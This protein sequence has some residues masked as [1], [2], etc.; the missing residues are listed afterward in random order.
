MDFYRFWA[1]IDFGLL[2]L[3]FFTALFFYSFVPLQLYASTAFL[4]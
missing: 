1:F 4:I 3:Y 2:Q